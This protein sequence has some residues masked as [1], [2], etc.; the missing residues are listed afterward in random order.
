MSA[1]QRP[2]PQPDSETRFYWDAA[3]D[4]RLAILRCVECAR[5]VHYPRS[6]CPSCAGD[7][8]QPTT[9][10]GKGKIYSFTVTHYASAP[11]FDR[12]VPFVVA[13][14]ELDEDPSVR[15]IA[16]VRECEASAVRI[17]MPVEVLYEDVT[18]TVTLPQFRPRS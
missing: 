9:V 5:F 10:S 14:V 15:L 18:E 13:L 17:G 2:L 7:R 8:L 1:G 11:G 6:A 4:H 16:N 3:R 12:E